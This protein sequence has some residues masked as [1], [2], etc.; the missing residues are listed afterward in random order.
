MAGGKLYIV[1][2]DDPDIPEKAFRTI[3]D[4]QSWAATL[5]SSYWIEEAE[6]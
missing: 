1:H 3:W 4:A 6:A 5:C 2:P